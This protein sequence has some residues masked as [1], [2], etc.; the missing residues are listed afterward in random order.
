M[1][2]YLKKKIRIRLW[3]SLKQPRIVEE[4]FYGTMHSKF[5]K[6]NYFQPRILCSPNNKILKKKKT[7]EAFRGLKKIK[8]SI[9]ICPFIQSYL[10]Y[11]LP[12]EKRD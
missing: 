5:W 12:N 9:F 6:E 3:N 2:F 10:K 8:M 7:D 4:N 1:I 11:D